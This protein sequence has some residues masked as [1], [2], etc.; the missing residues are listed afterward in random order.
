M[1]SK[2]LQHY[3]F[4]IVKDGKKESIGLLRKPE[5][6]MIYGYFV[7]E[8]EKGIKVGVC[9]ERVEYFIITPAFKYPDQ[10]KNT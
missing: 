8:S 9:S 10:F 2:I 1:V 3:D 5:P 4:S 6:E 7:A